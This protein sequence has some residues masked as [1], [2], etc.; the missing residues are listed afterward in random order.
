MFNT[1]A[2]AS[3]VPVQSPKQDVGNIRVMFLEDFF[4]NLLEYV[5]LMRV[6]V[7]E[8]SL[9]Y[10]V[11]FWSCRKIQGKSSRKNRRGARGS[12][13][14]SRKVEMTIDRLQER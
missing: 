6:D 2:F 11:S 5:K 12:G 7:L 14:I 4:W 13:Y 8:V 1:C 9:C 3:K 10:L